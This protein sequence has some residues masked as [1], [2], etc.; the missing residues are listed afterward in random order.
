MLVFVQLVRAVRHL[1]QDR[2]RIGPQPRHGPQQAAE[3]QRQQA[4]CLDRVRLWVAASLGDLLRQ[5]V[6]H[7]EHVDEQRR[8]HQQHDDRDVVRNRVD[9]RP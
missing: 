2:L 8:H 7:P 5:D 6:D 1:V 4:Q 9:D 3:D